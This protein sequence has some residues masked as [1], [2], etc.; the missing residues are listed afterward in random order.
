MTPALAKLV[1]WATP[2]R[3]SIT[4]T[5]SPVRRKAWAVQTPMM[6]APTTTARI[7]FDSSWFFGGAL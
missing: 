3:R 5:S 1:S 2:E 4:V 7:D 6:P